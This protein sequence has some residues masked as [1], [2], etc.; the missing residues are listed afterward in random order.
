ML[1]AFGEVKYLAIG[2]VKLDVQEANGSIPKPSGIGSI[3]LMELRHIRD[4]AKF[5]E[6]SETTILITSAR[7]PFNIADIVCGHRPPF[8]SLALL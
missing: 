8:R 6:L 2:F 5:K 7:L 4:I 1:N 3:L